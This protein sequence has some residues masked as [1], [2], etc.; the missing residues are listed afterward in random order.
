MDLEQQRAEA[1]GGLEPAFDIGTELTTC[2]GLTIQVRSADETDEAMLAEFF[3]HVTPEDLR[4]RFL[5]A[6]QNV[7]HAQLALLTQ[8]DH[9]R[10]E[11]F[12][13]FDIVTGCLLA[14][15]M[16]AIEDDVERAEVAVVIRS[17]FKNRGI[18]WSLLDHAAAQAAAMG[19]KTLQAIELPDN[20]TAIRVELDMGF[21]SRPYPGDAT[22]TLLEKSLA[23][24]GPEATERSAA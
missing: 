2:S 5:S 1:G 15:A 21:T 8:V 6:I 16:L 4:F 12:L 18:G 24:V 20:R 10:V 7:A 14:S 23:G 13:A 3:T 11:N 17:D 19:V 9:R 22:L